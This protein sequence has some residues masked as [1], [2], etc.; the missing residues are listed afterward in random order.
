MTNI[1]AMF[2]SQ[3]YKWVVLNFNAWVN[4]VMGWLAPHPCYGKRDML[5]QYGPLGLTQTLLSTLPSIFCSFSFLLRLLVSHMRNK[6]EDSVL[7]RKHI[8]S[9]WFFSGPLKPLF[10]EL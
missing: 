7:Q 3:V 1:L 4:P 6:S 5:R 10:S 9:K 2:L 8:A